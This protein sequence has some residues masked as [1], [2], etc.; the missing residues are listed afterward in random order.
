MVFT[1]TINRYD[2]FFYQTIC[3]NEFSKKTRKIKRK[4]PELGERIIPPGSMSE[5]FHSFATTKNNPYGMKLD[6]HKE[7]N[8][9]VACSWKATRG[10]EG[11]P[12][13]LHGGAT[14]ALVDELLAYAVYEKYNTYAITLSSRISWFDKTSINA[15]INSQAVV[16]RK[17]GRFVK[18][19][20]WVINSQGK[21]IV[22]STS[23]FY[24][25]TRRQFTRLVG[26]ASLPEEALPYCG[27]D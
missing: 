16:T 12:G 19:K 18:V 3:I 11:Y 4:I 13:L 21:I 7:V 23:L 17:C 24:I 8:G 6:I 25:P 20:G 2:R 26:T 1:F 10:F 22:E 5:K 27:I 15:V 9:G 14:L